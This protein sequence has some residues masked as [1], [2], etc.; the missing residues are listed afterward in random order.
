MKLPKA[1]NEKMGVISKYALK[2][3]NR[4]CDA[5]NVGKEEKAIFR[6]YVKGFLSFSDRLKTEDLPNLDKLV[7]NRR[8]RQV[9]AGSSEFFPFFEWALM[10]LSLISFLY[11][12][13][14][15]API[16]SEESAAWKIICSSDPNSALSYS[17]VNCL[18]EYIEKTK[19][20]EEALKD[21]DEEVSI[22]LEREEDSIF[23]TT[24]PAAQFYER[25]KTWE[26]LLKERALKSDFVAFAR[27][28]LL[29]AP[30]EKGS[31]TPEP[32]GFINEEERFFEILS[33]AEIFGKQL[34][35]YYPD[36]NY[37]LCSEPQKTGGATHTK[38]VYDV[39]N[40]FASPAK[41]KD[42]ESA[43]FV[44]LRILHYLA[45][46]KG[47]LIASSGKNG[48][49]KAAAAIMLIA[50]GDH[51]LTPLNPQ[52]TKFKASFY[53]LYKLVSQDS[54]P[55][56]SEIKQ[57]IAG[58][59]LLSIPQLG[60]VKGMDKNGK[61]SERM[62]QVTF[63]HIFGNITIP[64]AQ[65]SENED[66]REKEIFRQE[67]EFEIDPVL[68]TGFRQTITEEKNGRQETVFTPITHKKPL[69]LPS[70]TLKK[71]VTQQYLTF[72][73]NIK[74]RG[75]KTQKGHMKEEELLSAVFEYPA[76]MEVAKKKD[77]DG[78]I[79]T[80]SE[81]VRGEI[82]I[83]PSWESCQKREIQLN[84]SNHRKQLVKLFEQAK[85]QGIIV[86]FAYK[87]SSKTFEWRLVDLPE[88]R[89]K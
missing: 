81:K 4:I 83:F 41:I 2:E 27:A 25:F 60:P 66:E 7:K 13:M 86:S 87:A 62:Q 46:Q 28:V 67:I 64:Q 75:T 56:R 89:E 20:Q 39:L 32:F 26:P 8:F 36:S 84:R 1:I 33:G 80:R 54:E 9:L 77:E 82:K 48:Y 85:E 3:V 23:Y 45:E 35:D 49:A 12:D 74:T 6:S 69:L 43:D 78:I 55:D 59:R 38:V 34:R 37:L 18:C 10:D 76:L 58:M 88:E 47:S 61:V 11:T 63:L 17:G 16:W 14:Q 70:K 52:R 15:N 57:F 31:F 68:I 73:S 21:Y 72:I 40:V 22:I 79:C 29:Y 50:S 65:D 19:P 51:N 5:A 53:K 42:E 24:N 44:S 30:E 71:G